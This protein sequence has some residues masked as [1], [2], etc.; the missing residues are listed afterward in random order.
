MTKKRCFSWGIP[1]GDESFREALCEYLYQSRGV[2][3]SPEQ[4]IIGA[5]NDYLL[6]LLSAVSGHRLPGGHGKSHLQAGVP[7]F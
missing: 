7:D 1:R 2:K 5:G 6:M 4:V 3:C